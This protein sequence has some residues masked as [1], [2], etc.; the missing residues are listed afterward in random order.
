MSHARDRQLTEHLHDRRERHLEE[1]RRLVAFRTVGGQPGHE[2]EIAACAQ[3][4][5]DR[6]QDAGLD[7][8]RVVQT[9]EHPVVLAES[10]RAGP[11]APTLLIYGHYD[12]QPPEP[13][14]L[15]SSPPFQLTERDGLL[16]GRGAADMKGN[17]LIYIQSIHALQDVEGRLPCN[18][19]VVI[20]GNEESNPDALLWIAEHC[21]EDLVA[22]AVVIADGGIAGPEDPTVTIGVRGMAA[23]RV[24]VTTAEGDLHSGQ[25][26]GA[27]QNAN[28]AL[29]RIVAG[30]HDDD[31]RVLVDGFYDDVRPA[32]PAQD[33]AAIDPIDPGALLVSTGATELVGDP[34]YS[35]AQRMR[36]RPTLEVVGMGGGYVGDGLKTIV[37]ARAEAVLSC[38]LVLAQDPRRIIEQVSAHVRAHAPRGA[39]VEVPWSMAGAW[40]A[41][42]RPDE[43]VTVAAIAALGDVWGRPARASLTGGSLP[44]AAILSRAAD[45]PFVTVAF[46]LPGSRIHAPD[47]H[48]PR[49]QF[50]RG[51]DV[52]TRM[53]TLIG[54]GG[55]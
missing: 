24:A 44:A 37:V 3:W 23:L 33:A 15:W 48:L 35:A 6:L 9:P 10:L 51:H 26:G 13:L 12:V 42:A 19:R 52:V 21:A 29:A 39:T 38:R 16:Y 18:L 34:D 50:E 20:E 53:L 14:E 4:L 45:A 36:T 49:E 25:F 43:P 47:E 2:P 7:R 27:I 1:L 17:L 41:R 32:D 5:R 22:D 28:H 54:E 40:P 46:G 8:A 31:G 55:R 11:D 30:L